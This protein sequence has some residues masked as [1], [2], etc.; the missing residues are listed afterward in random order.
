MTQLGRILSSLLASIIGIAVM[1]VIAT[2]VFYV[3]VFVVATGSSLAGIDPSDDF[4]VLSAALI[5][6][7]VIEIQEKTNSF[8][9][10]MNPSAS[11]TIHWQPLGRLPNAFETIPS[12]ITYGRAAY[13]PG[14]T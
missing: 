14:Q 4:V 2:V 1:V 6:V 3:T 10:W 12:H 11:E 5:V 9:G 7:A 8:R 13:C